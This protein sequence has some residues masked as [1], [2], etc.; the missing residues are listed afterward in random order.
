MSG[1]SAEKNAEVPQGPAKLPLITPQRGGWGR[2]S[3]I[4]R[5][6]LNRRRDL[7]HWLIR[8]SWFRLLGTL[9]LVYFGSAFC[10]ALAFLAVPG[11]VENA[12]PNSLVDAY[13]FSIQTLSTIGYGTLAPATGYAHV[14]VAV[15]MLTSLLLTAVATGLVFA[16]FARPTARLLF[17]KV[18]VIKNEGDQRLLMFR[19][20]NERDGRIFDAHFSVSYVRT[21]IGADGSSSVRLL[22]LELRKAVAPVLSLSWNVVHE[23]NADSPLYGMTSELLA[24][25][26]GALTVNVSGVDDEVAATIH[27]NQVY[28][29]DQI[30]V[31]ARLVDVLT[32]DENGITQVLY[33]RFHDY[34]SQP[35]MKNIS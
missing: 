15:E 33:D 8:G 10:F 26:D 7:Y 19:V 16:K 32:Q 9:S 31:D 5:I 34:E 13:N 25:E 3:Q 4:K 11:A 28:G 1:P 18:A 24:A 22:D 6:G 14:V 35:E 20:A 21:V 29:V 17:S 2:N 23:I 30:I 27:V 12:R